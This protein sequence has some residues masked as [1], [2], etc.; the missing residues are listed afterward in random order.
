VTDPVR[1]YAEDVVAGRVVTGRLVRLA[2]ERHLKDLADGASRGLRFDHAEAAAALAF[3]QLCPHLKG[4]EAKRHE[5]LKLEPWQQFIIGSVYGWKRADGTR[6]FR[7]AWV[8][9][10]RKNGKSTLVYPAMLYGLALD[11]EQGGECYAIATMRDQ[12]RLVWEL[13]QKAVA[14]TPDLAAEIVSYAFY[15]AHPE[16]GSKC[17]ALSADAHT[18]DGLNPSTVVCDEIHQWKGRALWDVIETGMGARDQPLIWAITTAGEEGAENVYG[19]E[20]DHGVQVLEGVVQDDARF[21][22]VAALD[23]GDEWT[24]PKNFAK[25]NPNLGVSVKSDDLAAIIE[26]AKNMP[27]LANS[28][29]RLYL[30][31]RTQ[32]VDAWVPLSV[33]DA[34][35]DDRAT[36][37]RL[38]GYPCFGGLDLA[39][40]SDFAALALAFPLTEDWEPAP[41]EQRPALWAYLFRL[42]M[43]RDGRS[44]RETKL[45]EIA[46]PWV[47]AGHV[48]ATDGDAIDHGAIEAGVLAAAGQFAVRGV[49]CDPTNAAQIMTRLQQEGVSV[50]QCRPQMASMAGPTQLFDSDLT[51]KLVRHDGNPCVRWMV[52][53]AVLVQNGAGHRM[54]SRKLA[55]NKIDAVVAAVMA[56]GRAAAPPEPTGSYYEQ[57][58]RER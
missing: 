15:L 35:R 16:S 17:A 52:N 12:A 51:N 26:R 23:P 5:T 14:R 7:V 43:P 36:W 9:M 21:V 30:G 19:Q 37:D 48:A 40:T 29:K 56:R 44:H 11:G 2:A 45:R 20:H 46:R 24:D 58:R 31:I 41:D 4:R 38:K 55:K 18:L 47:S 49:A 33:W 39:S 34:G 13:A 54:P 1:Q 22:Y 27:S 25:A 53:N 28:A 32:D 6:R 42:W 3:W 10:G 50:V 57:P 8:E